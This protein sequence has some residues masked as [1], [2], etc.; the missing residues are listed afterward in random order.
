MMSYIQLIQCSQL[1]FCSQDRLPINNW[2]P[3]F[4]MVTVSE[5]RDEFLSKM[6]SFDC[7]CRA[8]LFSNFMLVTLQSKSHHAEPL[9]F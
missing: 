3:A 9:S 5:D 1:D 4:C 8:K 6:H 7:L 2:F